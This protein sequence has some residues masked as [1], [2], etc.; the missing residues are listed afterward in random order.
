MRPW[1]IAA[2]LL[3]AAVTQAEDPSDMTFER[4]AKVHRFAFGGTGYAGVIPQGKKDYR[5]ILF[6]PSAM[7]S[8]ERLLSVGNPQAK[9]WSLP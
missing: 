7:A 6:R 3:A 1:I 8:F 4:L 2:I 5:V 9:K